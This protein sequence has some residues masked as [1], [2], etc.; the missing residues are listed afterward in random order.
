M[1][2]TEKVLAFTFSGAVSG[3][4][5]VQ[6]LRAFASIQAF[7]GS[8]GVLAQVKIWGL[9]MDQMNAYSSRIPS[10]IQSA[11][12][13]GISQANLVIEGGDLG[14]PLV[15]VID[16][17]ILASFIELT[18]DGE[19]AFNVSVVGLYQAAAP[20]APLSRPGA[21]DAAQLI[22]ALC[23]GAPPPGLTLNNPS[24]AT[25]V[26]RNP[27]VYGSVI[28]Q[29]RKIAHSAG[30]KWKIEGQ[31]VWL[32]PPNGSPDDVTINVGPGTT[33]RMVGY[34]KYG[35]FGL[36]VTSLFNPQATVGRLVNVVGSAIQ[37]ANGLWQITNAV[38]HDLTTMLDKGPWF[39]T[40]QL[41]PLGSDAT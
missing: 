26:I 30:L 25:G 2:F 36:I 40:M 23:A 32:W 6:G 13:L 20:I 14:A 27:S 12:N 33:P 5:T 7:D 22:G 41:S 15:K 1:A 10:A 9:S 4:F 17:P 38:Q 3:S 29:I 34:P 35:P 31:N 11:G 19:S 8:I 39:T 28:D 37:K 24:G 21:Q 18:D 16:A